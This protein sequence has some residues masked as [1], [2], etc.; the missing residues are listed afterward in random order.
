M[1][2]SSNLQCTI[3]LFPFHLFNHLK[4][5][6][7]QLSLDTINMTMCFFFFFAHIMMLR[8]QRPLTAIPVIQSESF[9]FHS[10]FLFY[11]LWNSS[12]DRQIDDMQSE[13]ALTSCYR[14][15]WSMIESGVCIVCM[16]CSHYIALP[17][18]KALLCTFLP[19]YDLSTKRK[20]ERKYKGVLFTEKITRK[21]Q[22]MKMKEPIQIWFI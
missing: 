18:Q 21:R 8:F 5:I 13:Q 9:F 2:K 11:T 3:S 15:T 4:K 17:L 22:K 6:F 20:N 10:L 14:F 12:I 7:F 16:W 1:N 19:Y